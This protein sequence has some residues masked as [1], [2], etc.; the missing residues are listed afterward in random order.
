VL[1]AGDIAKCTNGIPAT[2]GAQI[3]SDMLL[4][5][6]GNLFTLGDNSNNSGSATDYTDCFDPT[7]GRLK[8]RINPVIGNHE[9]SSDGQG[10]PYFNYFGA[11][12]HPDKFGHYSMDLGAW[13]IVVLNAEC[14]IG[15][16][17]CGTGSIQ[18]TW[19]RADLAAHSEQC[20]LA[21][22]HQPLFTSG[23]Q[24]AYTGM[25]AFWQALYDYDAE[26]VLNGHNHNYERF[27]PQDPNAVSDPTNGLREFV[28][29]TGGA[30]LDNSIFPMAVNQ[31]IRNASA[32]GYLKLTLKPGS[33]DWEF[34]PQPGKTFTDK[35]S[36]VCH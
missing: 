30:S 24:S 19:L 9:L 26:I 10:T 6:S 33:Y 5:A 13:H 27:A 16:Q 7:W 32:Y 23:T 22:W 31:V 35:G 29:G 8:S 28:V 34:V 1:A 4:N 18:E 20:T 2:N 15:N 36:G 14:G 3:T 11:A 21:L 25:R 12:S 17:G